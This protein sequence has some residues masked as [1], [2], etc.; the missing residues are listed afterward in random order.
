MLSFNQITRFY[1]HQYLL[2]ESIN[3]LDFLRGDFLREVATE[4]IAFGWV[5]PGVPIHAQPCQGTF[6]WSGGYGQ[7]KYS[8]YERLI[9]F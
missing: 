5:G 7:V 2:S 9:N 6:D 3:I 8:S 4:T 1:A